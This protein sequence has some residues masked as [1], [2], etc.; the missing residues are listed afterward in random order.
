ML[1][2]L[3]AEDILLDKKR[4]RGRSSTTGQYVSMA[5]AKEKLL[6]L[7]R[8]ELDLMEEEILLSF[9]YKPPSTRARE[10]LPREEKLA[11]QIC[12][13]SSFE[14]EKKAH[15]MLA[16]FWERLRPFT[17]AAGRAPAG[18]VGVGDSR[19]LSYAAGKMRNASTAPTAAKKK[20]GALGIADLKC[21]RAITGGLILKISG[22]TPVNSVEKADLLVS[23]MD[24]VF[25]E[26]GRPN[27]LLFMDGNF[28]TWDYHRDRRRH[29]WE[30]MPPLHA[31]LE[32]GRRDGVAPSRL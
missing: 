10:Q 7:R 11:E 21:K 17:E 9:N 4:R 27:C 30:L 12:D 22:K 2:L 14:L 32:V 16:A 8:E 23:Q 24:G 28:L 20:K 1:V 15:A 6:A 29:E 31:V 5:E 19:D 3:E 25:K 26:M 18:R 13:L